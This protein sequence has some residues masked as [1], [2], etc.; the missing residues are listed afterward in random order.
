M[1][2]TGYF[3]K[4]C[5]FVPLI[6]IIPKEK[7]LKIFCMCKCK[8][9]LL[10]Y[11]TFMKYYYQTNLNYSDIP[12]EPIYKEYIDPSQ[13]N[14]DKND[15]N[16]DD[17]NKKFN[18]IIEQI[19]EFNLEIK[20][21]MIEKLNEKIKEIEKI[22]ESN[23]LNN[24]KI[25]N[26]IKTLISNYK[27]NNNNSSNIKNLLYNK[28]F[29]FSYKYESYSKLNFNDKNMNLD[30]LMRNVSNF[31]KSNY[32]LKSNNEQLYMFKTF[33]NHSKEVT[34]EIEVNDKIIASSS[35]DSY[36]ILYDLEKKKSIYKYKAHENGVNWLLK[37]N[38]NSNIL[39]C[40]GDKKIKIWPKIDNKNLELVNS[41][42]NYIATNAKEIV[43]NP[44]AEF[45]FEDPII[46]IIFIDNIYLSACSS[47]N[48]YLIKFEIINDDKEKDIYNIKLDILEKI[49][50]DKILDVYKIRNRQNEDLIVVYCSLKLCFLSFPKLDLIKEIKNVSIDKQF[51]CIT[52]ITK[53]D[54][55]VVS[56]YYL[57]LININN[58]QIKL[59]RL[60]FAQSTFISK[61]RDNTILIG[62]KDGIKRLS[63]NNLEEITLINKSYSVQNYGNYGNYVNQRISPEK[64][65]Y[66][67]EFSDGSLAICSSHGNIQICKFKIS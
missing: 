63:S 41:E 6:Q 50:I 33:F 10:N 13:K 27:S 48:V 55:L 28:N 58:Y 57:R 22:Y 7:D 66:V 21:K 17:I 51:N 64:F 26:I 11:D 34:C 2:K 15:I 24:I 25:E 1:E 39:S 49:N 36:I 31:F 37:I 18:N 47:K 20:T 5:K 38:K 14:D 54:I 67:Y 40:G 12:N 53:D 59:I 42:Y 35:K 44:I 45:D 19:N 8:K 46:K 9:Q 29:N 4:K 62:T 61:L 32:I 52:Q 60:N 3:C 65:N 16:L 30:T 23:R 56:S 43:I